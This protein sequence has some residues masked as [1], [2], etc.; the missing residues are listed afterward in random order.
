MPSIYLATLGGTIDSAP[1]PEPGQGD[2][3]VDAIMTDNPRAPLALREIFA[4][5]NSPHDLKVIKVCEK[6]SKDVTVCNR[7]FLLGVI[8]EAARNNAERV[9]VTMGTD[10]MCENAQAI[11]A[12]WPDVPIPVVFA[13]AIWPL[14]NGHRSDGWD[15]LRKAS[16]QSADPG[17]YIVMGEV[18]APA[19]LVTKDFDRR[20]FVVNEAASMP[21]AP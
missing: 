15:N 10:R 3:P 9:I 1:Y 17:V 14:A 16:F 2:Y 21:S 20:V 13:G 12:E 19:T 8:R 18:F 7:S 5:T 4:E 6:D 11:F